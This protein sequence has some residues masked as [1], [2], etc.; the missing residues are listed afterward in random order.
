MTKRI[1]YTVHVTAKMFNRNISNEDI[2]HVIEN[3][4]VIKE[5][6]EDK[7]FPSFLVFCF[8][9]ERPLHVVYSVN[10]KKEIII[11]TAYEPDILIWNP[12]FRTKKK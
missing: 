12:D 3:G 8:S 4:R 5:Y 7:P 6:P 2:E 9:N 1:K 11:N 10:D